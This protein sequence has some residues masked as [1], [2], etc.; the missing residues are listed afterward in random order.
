MNNVIRKS[1][2]FL[3]SINIILALFIFQTGFLL[4]RQIIVM[5]IDALRYD[6]LIPPSH[7]SHHNYYTGQ[8]K[9]VYEQLKAGKNCGIGTLIADPPTT[10]LQRIKA[11]TTGTLPT[12]IDAGENFSPDAIV[13]EDNF[14]YQANSLGMNVS[15]MGDDTWLSLYP[16]QFSKA[17]VHYSFDINDLNTVDDKI[18]PVFEQEVR[19]SNSSIIIAH[20]LGVDH[21]GHK[22]GPK[23]P[24]MADTLRKMDRI[25]GE[26]LNGMRDDDLLMVIG[27][28]GMT[29]T[30][31]HGGDSDDEVKAGIFVYAKNREIRLP[32]QPI[33]QIDIV[34]TISLLLGL[35]IPFSNLGTAILE[36]FPIEMRESVVAMNYEQIKRFAETYTLQKRFGAL[37]EVTAR[38]VNSMQDQIWAMSRIQ[39]TLRDAWTQFDD[40]YIII[41]NICLIEAILFLLSAQKVS[42]E[43]FIVRSGCI[44]LQCALLVDHSESK[45][46]NTLLTMALSVS[47]LSSAI[48]LVSRKLQEGFKIGVA[49]IAFVAVVLHSVSQ[50][51]NSFV[52][53]EAMVTRYLIQGVLL[54]S[55]IANIGNLAKKKSSIWSNRSLQLLVIC[56]AILRSEPYFHRC[57]EEEV[58]CVQH[59]P[60]QIF[61]SLSVDAQFWRVL[62][63]AISLLGFNY[64]FHKYFCSP[65]TCSGSLRIL[66]ALSFPIIAL[67]SF[68]SILQVLPNSSF[69]AVITVQI[70]YI[71]S[72]ISVIVAISNGRS[73]YPFAIQ[74]ALWPCFLIVGDG[75]QPALILYITLIYLATRIVEKDE[76]PA[77][78]T[79]LITYGF[80]FTG[81]SPAISSIPWHAAFIG[82]SGN[83]NFRL[84]S[85]L[86][87]MINLNISALIC[88]TF[89]VL[90]GTISIRRVL[91]LMAIRSLFSCFAASVHRRHLMV[92]KIFAPK[93]IFE[94]VLFISFITVILL[95]TIVLRRKNFK[96]V[97]P[98]KY[99]AFDD[100][101]INKKKKNPA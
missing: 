42:I 97:K 92:W 15:I 54:A 27:D 19:E 82:I 85:G 11:L 76:L 67:I 37:Y 89:T 83:S 61:S 56:L 64:G 66:R 33:S 34:P 14:L 70:I 91:A 50:F 2:L 16:E 53:Y 62:F 90:L 58:D 23:H 30:G 79:L 93:F 69:R 12:F 101:D 57:R 47:C 29:I 32:T 39:R 10:T 63:A 45:A 43:W 3:V 81:H 84:L 80:Y 13:N 5:L 44:L 55:T 60:A 87:V 35:P 73:G 96:L 100:E 65:S 77:L 18:K 74:S 41:G 51:S 94:N 68:H 1:R 95:T 98:E 31:D 71:G 40:S 48:S 4:K 86:L 17:F 78:I 26:T 9:N 6:F 7:S 20:F 59:Y 22:Y 28:H 99:N 75:Q 52:I 38:E 88:A 25:I 46:A 72:L 8:M 36:L 49:D 21:C 24:V